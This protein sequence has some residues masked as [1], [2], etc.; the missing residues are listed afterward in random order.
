VKVSTYD[1]A[2]FGSV[3]GEL[4][5]VSPSTF[6]GPNI[7]PFYKALVRLDHNYAGN[8]PATNPL[9]PGMTVLADIKTDERTVLRFLLN[10]VYR[11]I[12]TA[13]QER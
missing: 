9:L 10:P 13:F 7:A 5:H 1:Y 11:A 12:D 3:P 6:H 2:Q 8:N 4:V